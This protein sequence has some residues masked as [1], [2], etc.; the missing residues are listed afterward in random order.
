MTKERWMELQESRDP[1]IKISDAELA[2]GW[3]WCAEFDGLLVGPGMGELRFCKCLPKDHP[4][5]ATLPEDPYD[6]P[7][8]AAFVAEMAKHCRCLPLERRPCDG[9][10]AGG[11]CDGMGRD[12]G[13]EVEL[14]EEEEE[15]E[16]EPM[17]L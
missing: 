3:H 17:D 1:F 10:L 14:E 15:E 13:E 9:V 8:Y 7:E 16:E 6:T 4:A 11:M 2:L 12:A 5:F